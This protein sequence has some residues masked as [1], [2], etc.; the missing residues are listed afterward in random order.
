MPINP[1]CNLAAHNVVL[2]PVPDL[3]VVRGCPA[4]MNK[5][6][7][8]KCACHWFLECS[9][10]PGK[11]DML[12][13]RGC[14]AQQ[15]GQ[16]GV[17]AG[18]AHR[19]TGFN[20]SPRQGCTNTQAGQPNSTACCFLGSL[21][22]PFAASPKKSI[23]FFGKARQHSAQQ[24]S[25]AQRSAAQHKTTQRS[26]AAMHNP[27]SSCSA[28]SWASPVCRKNRARESHSGCTT[29]PS[30][31]AQQHRAGPHRRAPKS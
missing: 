29:Q 27:P 7:G 5:F 21:S 6:V 22:K 14:L 25:A 8:Q 2:D 16:T 1:T 9:K 10:R 19:Y 23:S 11:G 15:V 28:Q 18:S 17:Q 4:N 26:T 3:L 31:H 12:V 30:H 13:V 24:R 20:G